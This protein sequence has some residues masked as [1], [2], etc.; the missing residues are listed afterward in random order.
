MRTNV[1]E[2]L[3]MPQAPNATYHKQCYTPKSGE[4]VLDVLR[5]IDDTS[6]AKCKRTIGKG[7]VY[8]EG[9]EKPKIVQRSLWESE[10]TQ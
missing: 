1:I 7:P 5:L 4:I 2:V 6:C 8:E 3:R 9:I 10:V